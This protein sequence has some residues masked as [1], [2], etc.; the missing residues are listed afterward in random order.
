MDKIA[1]LYALYKFGVGGIDIVQ[2][3]LAIEHK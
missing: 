1:K 2:R 3:N